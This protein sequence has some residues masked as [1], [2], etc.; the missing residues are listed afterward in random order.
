MKNKIITLLLFILSS[1]SSA[2]SIGDYAPNFSLP[3]QNGEFKSL[4]Q[5]RNNWVI[6]YFYPMD[7]TPGCTTEACSFRDAT[8][9]IIAKNAVIYGVSIDSVESHKKF[10][11]KYTLPFSLLSDINGEVSKNYDSLGSFLTWKV[12]I[13]N[14]FI[15]NPAGIIVKKYTD[16]NPKKHAQEVLKDL[17]TLQSNN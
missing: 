3:D 7:D 5:H 1:S 8:D 10:S 6:I 11:K 14:T 2:L 12:A 4:K 17:M 13:R 15:I 16:V 9:H